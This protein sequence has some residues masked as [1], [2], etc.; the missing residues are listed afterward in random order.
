MKFCYPT[1]CIHKCFSLIDWKGHSTTRSW[2]HNSR[3]N[4]AFFSSQDVSHLSATFTWRAWKYC[5]H[6]AVHCVERFCLPW[7]QNICSLSIQGV[8][9]CLSKQCHGHPALYTP[10]S[11]RVW[12]EYDCFIASVNYGVRDVTLC[13][14][15][16]CAWHSLVLITLAFFICGTSFPAFWGMWPW[17]LSTS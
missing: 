14:L 1:A 3:I 8:H 5:G 6:W 12:A 2:H 9:V 16:L 11:A 4:H 10:W 13:I 7:E 15:Y 17:I